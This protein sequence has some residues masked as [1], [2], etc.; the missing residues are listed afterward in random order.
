MV[1]S[2][3]KIFLN[4]YNRKFSEFLDVTLAAIESREEDYMEIAKKIDKNVLMDY[5]RTYGELFNF[6]YMEQKYWDILGDVCMRVTSRSK[7]NGEFYTPFHICRF[8]AAI[9][10]P[11][12]T[13]KVCD[14]CL[15][16]GA[17]LIAVKDHLWLTKKISMPSSNLHGMDISSDAIKMA[18][19]QDYLTDYSYMERLLLTKMAEMMEKNQE[20]NGATR[21]LQHEKECNKPVTTEIKQE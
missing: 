21:E 18:K 11:K 3:S 2:I 13:D 5:A 20:D 8:M 10:D 19:I 14:P 17:M 15:G 4:S 6:F 12:E 9:M 1:D 7:M 16:S